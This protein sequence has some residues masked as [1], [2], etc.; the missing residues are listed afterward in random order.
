MRNHFTYLISGTK[1]NVFQ[2]FFFGE[3][4]IGKSGVVKVLQRKWVYFGRSLSLL[5][6]GLPFKNEW[7]ISSLFCRFMVPK[8]Y[9]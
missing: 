3:A 1:A 9:H 6:T 8:R 4:I 5:Q 2:D 7:E